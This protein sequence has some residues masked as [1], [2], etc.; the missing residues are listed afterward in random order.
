M[1]V[2][3]VNQREVRELLS[4]K[5]CMKE[6][7]E[8]LRAL[9]RGDAHMP[10]RSVMWLPE[11]TGALGMMPSYMQNLKVMGLKVISVFPGN[12]GTDYDSHQGAVMLFDTEHGQPLAIVEASA[13]T[14][15]RTAAV[16]GVATDLL[17]RKDAGDLAILGAGTQA[18]AHLEAMLLVRAVRRV[19]VW[20]LHSERAEE[21][22]ERASKRHGIIVE[23]MATAFDAVQG[24]DIICTTTSSTD[25]VLLGEWIREGTHINAIGACIPTSREL[26]TEAVVKSRLF[27]DRRESTLNEAGDFLIP[28][29]EG[30]IGDDHIQ[31]EIGEILEGKIQGR[32]TDEEIT[33]FESLGLAVEDLAA[34]RYIYVQAM[35]KGAGTA[36][37]LGGSRKGNA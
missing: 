2:L 21:F 16:S 6:M 4:M 23:P 37:E 26:D 25:P 3:I 24:A 35:E 11:M 33:L 8:A 22:A 10:L 5:A 34:A 13:I 28:K 36:L 18:H 9:E 7:S 17:A 19:R 29:G 12:V 1:E 15:I 32:R 14:A 20:S 30:A 27:V 31:G